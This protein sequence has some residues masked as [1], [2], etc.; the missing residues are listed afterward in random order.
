MVVAEKRHHIRFFPQG[1]G[2]DQNGNPLPGVVV[3]HDVTHPFENDIYL[4]SHRAIQGTARPT[5][6]HM[7]MD[8]AN[9]PVDEFQKMLYE[10]CYQYI[11]STTPVSL[12]PAV[13]YAHLASNRARAHENIS[14]TER[15]QRDD[16]GP[17]ESTSDRPKE[18]A[19]PLIAMDNVD[20][21]R[22][23]MWFV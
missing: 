12:H 18:E 8:E 14:E 13:Y 1:K 17:T 22:Y 11:R 20:N 5:H 6:Y 4:C 3:D 19:K 16:A 2:G 10:Q 7:L 23:G 21:I 15:K 9:V